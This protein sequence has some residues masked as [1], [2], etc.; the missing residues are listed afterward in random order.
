LHN[1]DPR[2]YVLSS[3]IEQHSNDYTSALKDILKAYTLTT[4]SKEQN[5]Y[6]QKAKLLDNI[7]D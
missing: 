6:S 2:F 4:S 5:F 3:V 1:Q 7:D